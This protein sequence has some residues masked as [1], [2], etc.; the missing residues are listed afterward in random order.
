MLPVLPGVVVMLP[1]PRSV[2]VLLEL[3]DEDGEVDAVPEVEGDVE[4]EDD[5]PNEPLVLPEPLR[6][7][8]PLKLP[9]AEPFAEELP[10]E[11]SE[12][13]V[14]ELAL[15]GDVVLLPTLGVVGV[16]L[17]D[18]DPNALPD[19]D[20][21]GIVARLSDCALPDGEVDEAL[22]DE[23]GEMDD[24]EEAPVDGLVDDGDEELEVCACTA[25][26]A[27]K[28]AAVPQPK[29]LAA[30][31][32]KNI[33]FGIV[34]GPPARMRITPDRRCPWRQGALPGV[35]R[36]KPESVLGGFSERA[37]RI[38]PIRSA[39]ASGRSAAI[40]FDV[41]PLRA[42]S[43]KVARTVRVTKPRPDDPRASGWCGFRW[44]LPRR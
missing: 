37:S 14:V 30:V 2:V 20:D 29:N 36:R 41:P 35:A 28:N 6:L 22:E 24:E 18:E 34:A 27:A 13:A 16:E 8:A 19:E 25:N 33:W 11:R 5:V 23:D 31:F 44:C 26:V 12:P 15:P 1:L 17:L 21:E 32:I 7:P 42:H 4:V 9:E 3:V 38:F 43:L 40:S 10:E 39:C